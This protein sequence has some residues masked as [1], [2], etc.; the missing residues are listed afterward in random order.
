MSKLKL[1]QKHS[2]NSTREVLKGILVS[3]P[4]DSP[5]LDNLSTPDRYL[6]SLEIKSSNL[7][8]NGQV[9]V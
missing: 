5:F 8:T 6:R 1:A 9:L 2:C 7:I 4:S 3:E